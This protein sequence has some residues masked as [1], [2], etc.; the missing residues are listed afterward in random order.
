MT[1]LRRPLWKGVLGLAGIPSSRAAS[2]LCRLKHV[3]DKFTWAIA[4]QQSQEVT[5]TT[6]EQFDIEGST[7][8]D[9]K[10]VWDEIT[11]VSSSV[12]V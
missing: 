7:P 8:Y 3:S 2:S 11:H 10:A 9:A 4:A 5:V 12:D 6:C 1:S